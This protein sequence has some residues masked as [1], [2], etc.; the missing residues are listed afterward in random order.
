MGA[1]GRRIAILTAAALLSSTSVLA[2]DIPDNVKTF[3]D[4]IRKQGQCDNVLAGGFHS[5]DGDSGGMVSPAFY[6]VARH[7]HPS[8]TTPRL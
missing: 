8:N 3:V 1:L 7:A 5:S 4:K 2:R 6:A